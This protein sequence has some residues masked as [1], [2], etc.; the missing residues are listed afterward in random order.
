MKLLRVARLACLSMV[1]LASLLITACHQDQPSPWQLAD[2]SG[3][4]P[5]LT[6]QLTDDLGKTVTADTYRGKVVLLYFGY[7]HCPD[8]CP[9]TMA[10]LHVVM[11]RLGKLADNV[12]ILFVSVDPARDT[13][14][15]LHGYVTAFDPHAVGLT[16]SPSDIEAL[17][18]RYRAAF[19]REPGKADGSYDVSHS[20]GIYIFDSHGKARL[21]ATSSDPLDKVVHD[22][23]LLL[24]GDAT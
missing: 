1:L 10:H 17:T 12:R 9:L 5:D 16:G 15:V 2:I 14:A 19:T 24:G 20:S 18:K 23:R 8:V 21:L 7:T 22:L 4:M 11:Q 13:P 3:H 6:F